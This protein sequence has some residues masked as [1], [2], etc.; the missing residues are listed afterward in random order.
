MNDNL[1]KLLIDKIFEKLP[2]DVNPVDYLMNVLHISRK[3]IYRRKKGELPFSFDEIVILS[4]ELDFSI[5]ELIAIDNENQAIFTHKA[6]TLFDQ[7]ETFISML[8]KY[9]EFYKK[10]A[11]AKS[12]E[13]VFTMNRILLIYA[14]N[15]TH[16]FKFLYY[17]WIYQGHH[18]PLNFRYSEMILPPEI[19]AL[20]K[21]VWEY[22]RSVGNTTIILN[23][24]IFKNIFNEIT[25]YYQKELLTSGEYIQLKDELLAYIKQLEVVVSLGTNNYGSNYA[26]YLSKL[27]IESN[28][29][30]YKIDDNIESSFWVFGISPIHTNNNFV[31][32][33]HKKWIDSL[34][35]YSILIS[36]SNELLQSKFFNEQYNYIA[37]ASAN[38]LNDYD[39]ERNAVNL[40]SS[41]ARK[42]F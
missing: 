7:K 25:Y 33:S 10:A 35:K 11:Q 41:V 27:S 3:S 40:C 15:T 38:L 34:K 4:K 37:K 13:G 20:S 17:M 8:D 24:L 22:V 16:L 19:L 26:I 14:L 36:Q 28:S 32:T 9:L 12:Y 31:P 18:I 30:Y 23:E 21:K 6:D 39:S 1:D 2:S 5:D 42:D 29:C